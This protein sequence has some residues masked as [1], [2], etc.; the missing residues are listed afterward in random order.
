MKTYAAKIWRYLAIGTWMRAIDINNCAI[1]PDR[2]LNGFTN[3]STKFINVSLK[4]SISICRA[5]LK[6]QYNWHKKS[7]K[8]MKK[9]RKARVKQMKAGTGFRPVLAKITDVP[10]GMSPVSGIRANVRETVKESAERTA[11]AAAKKFRKKMT[12]SAVKITRSVIRQFQTFHM[13]R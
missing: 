6:I 9:A 1:K 8:T 13:N 7:R 4:R 11:E 3:V 5:H 10:E 12:R 2:P